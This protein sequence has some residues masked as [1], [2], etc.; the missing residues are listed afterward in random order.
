MQKLFPSVSVKAIGL[1]LTAIAS[2]AHQAAPRGRLRIGLITPVTGTV[3][4]AASARGVRLGAAEAKQTAKLFGANVELYEASGSGSG[5]VAAARRLSSARQVQLLIGSSAADADALSRYA[6]SREILF[7][8]VASRAPALRSACRRHT[9]HIEASEGMYAAGLRLAEEHP[10]I[11]ARTGT[12]PAAAYP[13]SPLLWS[14][15][16][17]RFGA[18]Q[19][20]DRYRTK[21][22]VP[23]D[24]SAWAGWAAVKIAAEAALRV[25][26]TQP[27]K[28]LGYLES[29]DT[30]FDGHKGWPLTFRIA[31]HQLRQPVYLALRSGMT[32]QPREAV[33]DIPELRAVSDT[34]ERGEVRG[35]NDVLD[36]L[37]APAPPPCPWSKH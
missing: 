18:A 31:D 11:S 5:A 6:E 19:I 29:P 27:S 30:K 24:G 37:S 23:M 13:D 20:N 34:S 33:T 25:G 4:T 2:S 17:Q 26:S 8:N 1:V 10:V 16:L 3:S 36:R 9:F 28:L 12:P 35:A 14:P 21:Y 15:Y 22:L 7:F 32:G